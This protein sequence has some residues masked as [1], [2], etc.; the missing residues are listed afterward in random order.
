MKV[1]AAKLL[2]FFN[3]VGIHFLWL[4]VQLVVLHETIAAR[5]F[6]EAKHNQKLLRKL[7]ESVQGKLVK[8]HPKLQ[9]N[10]SQHRLRWH[11]EPSHK[12]LLKHNSL[13]VAWIR[14]NFFTRLACRTFDKI[15]QS[16]QLSDVADSNGRGPKVIAPLTLARMTPLSS[17]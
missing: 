1:Y 5:F 3:P 16:L 14:N 13:V 9:Q 11:P 4:I 8:L 7:S 17:S 10:I 15:A 2:I 6:A 12:E